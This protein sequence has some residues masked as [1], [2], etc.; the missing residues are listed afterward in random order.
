[1]IA[2]AR[3]PSAMSSSEDMLRSQ[4]YQRMKIS[5]TQQWLALQ[6]G[7]CLFL[8]KHMGFQV[9]S[10]SLTFPD[11]SR[12]DINLRSKYQHKLVPFTF[13]LLNMF[14]SSEKGN[15]AC[16]YMFCPNPWPCGL[17]NWPWIWSFVRTCDHQKSC[18]LIRDLVVLTQLGL[19]ATPCISRRVKT[20]IP[21]MMPVTNQWNSN[22]DPVLK[23]CRWRRCRLQ[24]DTFR[25]SLILSGTGDEISLGCLNTWWTWTD[26][27][28]HFGQ[29]WRDQR[30]W[31]DNSWPLAAR[32]TFLAVLQIILS[33]RSSVQ[34][35]SS[36]F[37]HGA[38]IPTAPSLFS[39]LSLKW[40]G[41]E[42]TH[43]RPGPRGCWLQWS[44]S[45]FEGCG[46]GLGVDGC[47]WPSNFTSW[48]IVS[49]SI[50]ASLRLRRTGFCDFLKGIAVQTALKK[51]LIFPF[52]PNKKSHQ[53][54]QRPA[55]RPW[56]ASLATVRWPATPT[57]PFSSTRE[58]WDS[59]MSER[60]WS[61]MATVAIVY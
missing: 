22:L 43:S 24:K 42:Q 50:Y 54:C 31:S 36:M 10:A 17:W 46:F 7:F 28:S 2:I 52:C 47:R 4:Q 1:M 25:L 15:L 34:T 19:M 23:T 48:I 33:E 5:H 44:Q 58:P 32:Q 35:A 38:H 12:K 9:S 40:H 3:N 29:R 13:K 18:H 60:K 6:F 8:S 45:A 37:T 51:N 59:E 14:F 27:L 56:R 49:E 41:T 21:T 53:L 11:L 16:P 55:Q 39:F 57:K 61:K 26:R 20:L 30:S